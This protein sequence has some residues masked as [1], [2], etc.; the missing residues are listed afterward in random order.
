VQSVLFAAVSLLAA[1][2]EPAPAVAADP[3]AA[4]PAAGRIYAGVSPGSEARNPLGN[5]RSD[6]PRLVW[7]GF[8]MAGDRSEIFLQTTRTV[9]YELGDPVVRAGQPRLTVFLRNCRIHL[10]NNG[11]RIDTRFFASPV[12][13]VSARQRRKDVEIL[14]S[15]EAS[16]APSART[17]PGPD[18]TQFLVLSFPPGRAQQPAA[19]PPIDERA[20]DPEASVAPPAG[21]APEAAPPT[22]L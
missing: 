1:Q 11:R 8:K 20:L 15:L 9:S 6:P 2:A 17:E 16:A 10:R 3:A 18:G 14:V 5:P 19:A 21:V 12:E 4:V 22:G 7:T 13:E